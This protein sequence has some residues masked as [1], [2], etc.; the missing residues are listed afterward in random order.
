ML[1]LLVGFFGDELAFKAFEPAF[2]GREW[3]T[4]EDELGAAPAFVADLEG[5]EGGA[6]EDHFLGRMSLEIF[7]RALLADLL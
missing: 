3:D 5:V 7:F 1:E 6:G 2:L 4:E